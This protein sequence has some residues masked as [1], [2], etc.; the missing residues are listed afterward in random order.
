MTR[1]DAAQ[2]FVPSRCGFFAFAN[3]HDIFTYYVR[4]IILDLRQS[5]VREAARAKG[6]AP[7]NTN[8]PRNQ[9]DPDMPHPQKGNWQTSLAILALLTTG[10]AQAGIL[11]QHSGTANPTT[12]GFFLL[13]DT[14]PDHEQRSA[15]DPN[16]QGEDS[17]WFASANSGTGSSL[18]NYQYAPTSA[19]L[20]DMNTQ[21]WK[22]EMRV[23]NNLVVGNFGPD[24]GTD[25]GVGLSLLTNT[26]DFEI[27]IG[28]DSSNNMTLYKWVS[29]GLSQITL[30][31][32]VYAVNLYHTYAMTAAPGATQATIS[33]DGTVVGTVDGVAG[34]YTPLFYFGSGSSDGIFS[35]NYSQVALSTIPE[36]ASLGLLALGSLCLLRRRRS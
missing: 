29:G 28:T 35:V 13:S 14:R 1:V 7:K 20:S 23:L 16:W 9:G 32:A 36:P 5:R 12:E 34:S 31:P 21:G 8:Q 24:N 22:A 6:V 27:Y 33:I 11:V 2:H 30:D 10:A 26:L 4:H 17:W 19:Q 18:S 15:A 25:Y 3:A